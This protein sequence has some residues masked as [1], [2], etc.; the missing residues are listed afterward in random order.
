MIG[1]Y[2]HL[3]IVFLRLAGNEIQ[4]VPKRNVML[5]GTCNIISNLFL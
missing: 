1:G 3:L 4:L 5:Y 2:A